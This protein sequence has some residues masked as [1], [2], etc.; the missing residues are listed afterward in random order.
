[1]PTLPKVPAWLTRPRP[2]TRDDTAAALAN[3]DA[4][5]EHVDGFAVKMAT[6]HTAHLNTIDKRLDHHG[7]A[8]GR[9]TAG[10]QER[11]LK[12]ERLARDVHVLRAAV[13]SLLRAENDVREAC[14][15]A[16]YPDDDDN[17]ELITN[18]PVS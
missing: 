15:E 14:R 11:D 2:R 17:G 12:I 13:K 9:L 4:R 3:L 6:L 10:I 5:I 1:M 18:G 8:V 7:T 16:F